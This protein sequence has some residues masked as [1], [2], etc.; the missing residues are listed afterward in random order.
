[1][2]FVTFSRDQRGALKKEIDLPAHIQTMM[3][4]FQENLT[5]EQ[6]SDPRYSFAAIFVQKIAKR[7]GTAGEAIEFLAADSDLGQQINNVYIT[8]KRAGEI[9]A[10]AN[11]QSREREGFSAVYDHRPYTL[12]AGA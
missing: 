4:K 8:G 11:S 10:N 6:L 1:L 12:M 9:Q 5:E 7:K 2:Q 3:D